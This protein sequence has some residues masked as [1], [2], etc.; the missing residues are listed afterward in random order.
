MGFVVKGL[1]CET[2]LRYRDWETEECIV[3]GKQ[4][5]VSKKP[6]ELKIEQ[7]NKEITDLEK[8]LKAVS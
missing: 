5:S 8:S 3:T 2:V 4:R 7:T 6:I 1:I